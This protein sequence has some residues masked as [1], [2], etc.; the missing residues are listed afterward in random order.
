MIL[1]SSVNFFA[2]LSV[3]LVLSAPAVAQAPPKSKTVPVLSGED[4]ALDYKKYI[5]QRVTVED[6]LIVGARLEFAGCFPGTAV[7][8]NVDYRNSPR[9][10]RKRAME[11]CSLPEVKKECFAKV[12][13]KVRGS[14]T[15]QVIG[16][17]DA[18]L[19]WLQP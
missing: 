17:D 11:R 6:C 14:L 8:I 12:T 19:E 18:T 2:S 9:E 13:G 15:G 4:F 5:G 16:L 1:A 3:A 7:M 10:V